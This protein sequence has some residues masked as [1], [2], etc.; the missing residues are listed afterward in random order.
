MQSTNVST[1]ISM[2]LDG[3]TLQ[4][5]LRILQGLIYQLSKENIALRRESLNSLSIAAEYQLENARMR[6]LLNEYRQRQS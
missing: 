4:E 2:E 6:G 1:N 5:K 3:L